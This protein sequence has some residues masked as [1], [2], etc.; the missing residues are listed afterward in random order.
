MNDSKPDDIGATHHEQA[1]EERVATLER[2][3][4][5]MRNQIFNMHWRIA[6]LGLD[7]DDVR[8]AIDDLYYY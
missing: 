8:D 5:A 6:G 3:L 7:M 2:E 1:L 4:A